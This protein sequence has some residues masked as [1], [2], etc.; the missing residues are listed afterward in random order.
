M[1][2]LLY[3]ITLSSINIRPEGSVTFC[4]LPCCDYNCGEI[5]RKKQFNADMTAGKETEVVFV[6]I[7]FSKTVVRKSFKK[8]LRAF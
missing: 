4:P 2:A 5:Y 6:L 1:V 3:P 7:I 8:H